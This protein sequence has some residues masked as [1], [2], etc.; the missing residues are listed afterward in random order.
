MKF[1]IDRKEENYYICENEKKEFIKI[2]VCE[3]DF[4]VNDGDVIE[5]NE[6]GYFLLRDETEL[7]KERIENK[8]SSLLK[9]KL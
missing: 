8:F 5:K 6:N 1:V 7:R 3:L 2:P 4:K 9:K